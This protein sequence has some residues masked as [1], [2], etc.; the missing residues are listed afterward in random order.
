[1]GDNL[2]PNTVCK[3]PS[4]RRF[5]SRLCMELREIPQTRGITWFARDQYRISGWHSMSECHPLIRYWFDEQIRILNS[6]NI[7]GYSTGNVTPSALLQLYIVLED[8]HLH[9]V[10][11]V[12]LFTLKDAKDPSRIKS[13]VTHFLWARKHGHDQMQCYSLRWDIVLYS[14]HAILDT[15]ILFP[16]NL[17]Q[18]RQNVLKYIPAIIET[19]EINIPNCWSKRHL[20]N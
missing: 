17:K 14:S 19:Y 20:V 4:R 8:I 10:T 15:R 1:M 11:N 13:A 16:G 3:S 12:W 7:D 18:K 2:I 6:L 5:S 9:H